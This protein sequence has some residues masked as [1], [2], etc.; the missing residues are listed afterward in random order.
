MD[1]LPKYWKGLINNYAKV[2]LGNHSEATVLTVNIKK[3]C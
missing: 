3:E 2:K 1:Y